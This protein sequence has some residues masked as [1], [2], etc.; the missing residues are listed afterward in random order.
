MKLTNQTATKDPQEAT[1]VSEIMGRIRRIELNTRRLVDDSVAGQYHS[2]FRGRGMNF[3]DVR[4]YQPGDDIRSIDWNVTA[5]TGEPY[6]KLFTEERELT[7]ML[8]LDVSASG[9]YGG[10]QESKRQ[11]AAEAAAV[12]AFS[13]VQNGDK[14]GA[15]L[16]TDQTELFVPPKRGRLH[17]LRLIREML[18][19]RPTSSATHIAATL[20]DLNR[21][22]T[23]RSVLF[24]VSDFLSPDFSRP[25]AITARKHDLIAIRVSDPYEEEIPDV[26]W[27]TLEDPETGE[28]IGVNTSDRGFRRRYQAEILRQRGEFEKLAARNR[29]DLIDIKTGQDF[30]PALKAFFRVRE[31]RA[32]SR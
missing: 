18:Y 28:Q 22:L 8:V 29:V 7:V 32:H 3:E 25:L 5:R 16:F 11:I 26:G 20:D 30:L 6:I 1:S 21:L 4:R 15:A 12:L 19:F 17:T 31:K 2:V 9:A 27:T 23:R 24:V 10:S 14:V 13:A